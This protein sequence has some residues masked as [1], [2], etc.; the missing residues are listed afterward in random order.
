[1]TFRFASKVVSPEHGPAKEAHADGWLFLVKAR[2]L[3]VG[4]IHDLQLCGAAISVPVKTQE[5]CA[6]QAHRD[7]RQQGGSWHPNGS[8][9]KPPLDPVRESSSDKHGY[10]QPQT[11]PQRHTHPPPQAPSTSRRHDSTSCPRNAPTLPHNYASIPSTLPPSILNTDSD[12]PS[13]PPT[14]VTSGT[15]FRAHPST[16][17]TQN[18]ALRDQLDTAASDSRKKIHDWRQAIDERELAEK[19]R[20]APGWLD[21]DAKILR[22]ATTV[23]PPDT[24]PGA[25]LLDADE[26]NTDALRP[27]ESA[28][29]MGSQ[30]DRAFG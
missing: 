11:E 15:G 29:D 19:R 14:Y 6:T 26:Q 24:K 1:M 12:D 27:Q 3:E 25:S 2:P 16:I 4:P 8:D 28:N 10:H 23:P 5:G 20:K 17:I 30:M 18:K 13:A 7:T 9:P 22:P 21:S